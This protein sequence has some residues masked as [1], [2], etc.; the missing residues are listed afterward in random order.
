[1]RLSCPSKTKS[2][3]GCRLVTRKRRRLPV[4][5]SVGT[6]RCP[7]GY[8]LRSFPCWL[9][10]ASVPTPTTTVV[11][12]TTW[13]E[14]ARRS[15]FDICADCHGAEGEGDYGPAIIGTA[16]KSYGTAQRLFD[17]ISTEMPQ[18]RPGRLS[19]STYLQ[20]LAYIL[21]ESGFIQSEDI[22]DAGNLADVP[23]N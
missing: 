3:T 9:F 5:V 22:F 10:C 13:G 8:S 20:I 12:T 21:I 2:G 23:L 15:A 11:P 1:M 19:G 17:Y 7:S 6:P 4:D 18:D 14:V 16:L